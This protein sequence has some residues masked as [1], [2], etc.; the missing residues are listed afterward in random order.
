[1]LP[2]EK[3]NRLGVNQKLKSNPSQLPTSSVDRT[4]DR[5]DSL[6][7]Y[8]DQRQTLPS[9]AT[10]A[11]ETKGLFGKRKRK[12]KAGPTRDQILEI[13]FQ[14]IDTLPEIE[15]RM[16]RG[17]FSLSATTAREVMIPLSEM[18]AV[19]IATPIEQVKAMVH[20]STYQYLPVYEERID[21]LTGIVS[22]TDI[23]YAPHQVN[24]LSSFIRPAYY[25]PETKLTDDL[26]EELRMA[27]NPVAIIIDEHAGCVGC[28]MLEDI[29]EQIVGEIGCNHKRHNLH[30][31]PLD[32]G[33]WALDAR[34][35]IN[36]VNSAL[37]TNIPRD[38]CDTIGGFIL[39]LFGR[40]P[41]QGEK[42]HY[43]GFEFTIEEVF[44]YGI[45]VLHAHKLKSM[46][47]EEKQAN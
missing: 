18:I 17:I 24:E 27:E 25:V 23:L 7:V 32:N 39:K 47:P 15:A 33:S 36:G 3:F 29:L 35:S 28:V 11:D 8:P 10:R 13:L 20:H 31:E 6:I 37:G 16:L 9:R 40:L 1:V 26:L 42:V 19:H 46:A 44:G 45:A 12:N 41:E 22:I 4:I 34:T 30:V 38:G 43:N 5:P 14:W 2:P 21:R